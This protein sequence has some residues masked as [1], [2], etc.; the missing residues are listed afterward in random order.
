MEE[1]NGKLKDELQH[2]ITAIE[3]QLA[4]IKSQKEKK[5]QN[6]GTKFEEENEELRGLDQEIKTAQKRTN[7]YKKEIRVMKKQLEGAYDLDKVVALENELKDLTGQAES[8]D[9]ET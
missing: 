4:K 5:R 3:S 7:F 9:E 8:L 1:I 2:L 6:Y